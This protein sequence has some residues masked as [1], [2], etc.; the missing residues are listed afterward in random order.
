MGG[1]LY[2]G[3]FDR[4]L[5]ARVDDGSFQPIDGL[6]PFINTLVGDGQTLYV[7]TARGLYT[8]EVGQRSARAVPGLSEP[9][10]A[11][12]IGPG[13]ALAVGT[14]HGA[15]VLEGG[16]V[17]H[18]GEADGLPGRQCWA[19]AWSPG[20]SGAVL[21]VGTADGLVRF[22]AGARLEVF[23]QS[24]G[25]LPH[26]WVTALLWEG[27]SML[28]GTYDA[29]VV[30]LTPDPAAAQGWRR[31]TRLSGAWVN[32]MGLAR[33]EGTVLVSTLGG[34]VGAL[35]GPGFHS[36]LPGALDDVTAVAVHTVGRSGAATGSISQ[37]STAVWF[38]TRGGLVHAPEGWYPS[39]H[40]TEQAHTD[41]PCADGL[42]G[43][44]VAAGLRLERG[45]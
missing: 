43:R 16:R 41:S 17:R 1:V 31:E 23:T 21:W 28:V 12:A 10:N 45:R 29:G 39:A 11:L 7:G 20:P 30:G 37:R 40:D 9:V 26:D 6:P 4:G 2:A 18:L 35:G 14:S 13:R 42:P 25:H 15:Y 27:E 24:G 5:F 8:L 3:S 33:V 32:P 34:G 22:E 19:V 38:A 36:L 44:R